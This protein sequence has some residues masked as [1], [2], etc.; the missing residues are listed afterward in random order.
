MLAARVNVCARIEESCDRRSVAADRCDMKRRL[1]NRCAG[2]RRQRGDML[3]ARQRHETFE[4]LCQRMIPSAHRLTRHKI[5]D[6]ARERAW[7]QAGRTNYT[8]VTHRS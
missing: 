4:K 6:R 2:M 8:K 5:S 7:L 1:A 3:K